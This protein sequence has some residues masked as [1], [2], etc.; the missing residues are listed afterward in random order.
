MNVQEWKWKFCVYLNCTREWILF[1]T[2][3][4][5][6][7]WG[8]KWLYNVVWGKREMSRLLFFTFFLFHEIS[9]IIY[10][11]IAIFSLSHISHIFIIVMMWGGSE[12]FF[13]RRCVYKIKWIFSVLFSCYWFLL[14]FISRKFFFLYHLFYVGEGEYLQG[15]TIYNPQAIRA[16]LFFSLLFIFGLFSRFIF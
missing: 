6:A 7:E 10:I 3:D 12:N 4:W 5:K 13:F 1:V 2:L 16:L 9:S 15:N 14:N 8:W 11:M